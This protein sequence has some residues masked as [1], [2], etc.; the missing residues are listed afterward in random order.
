M[1]VPVRGARCLRSGHALCDRI[2]L[3]R[4]VLARTHLLS[5]HLIRPQ[6]VK[7]YQFNPITALVMAL[8]Y[9]LL[10]GVSPPA[11]LVI[12]LF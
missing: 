12:L 1:L 7:I 11:R 5:R 9:I 10:D 4:A 6:F 2:G 8:R 3:H